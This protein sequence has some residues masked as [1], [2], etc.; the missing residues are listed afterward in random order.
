MQDEN[1][2]QTSQSATN[3]QYNPEADKSVGSYED[4]TTRSSHEAVEWS[5]SE[6]IAHEKDPI[7]YATVAVVVLLFAGLIYLLDADNS[8][9]APFIVVAAGAIFVV[10]AA[11]KP[12]VLNYSIDES[13]LHVG[14][15]LYRFS[16]Y[17]SF[18]VIQEGAIESIMLTPLQRFLPSMTIYFEPKDQ[19]R[20]VDALSEY[21]PYEVKKQ[22]PIDS[23][24]RK[25]RF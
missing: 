13:G 23:F 16:D 15:K 2:Q 22:D 9:F 1:N 24:M 11:R 3:W 14:V 10:S 4:L 12:R 6:Y 20:I 7:W 5:A 8:W 21:L 25:I 18:S 17:K 19:S